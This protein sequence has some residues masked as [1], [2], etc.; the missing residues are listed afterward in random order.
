MKDST[1]RTL[2]TLIQ[3]VVAAAVATPGIYQAATGQDPALATG[4]ATA[5]IAAGIA[6]AAGLARVMALPAVDALLSKIGLGRVVEYMVLGLSMD[7][8]DK[9]DDQ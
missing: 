2:R 3:A 6:V 4:Y 5:T 1:R 8:E 7:A 9:A